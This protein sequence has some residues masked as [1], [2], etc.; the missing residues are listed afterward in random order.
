MV[1]RSATAT[2][3]TAFGKPL[4]SSV[5][6]STG[7]TA[8]STFGSM[9]LPIRSPMYSIGASSFSPSPITTTPS[10]WMALRRSRMALTAA[11]SSAFL[12]PRPIQRAAAS[13]AASVTRHSS[14]PMLRSSPPREGSV[15]P[16][17]SSGVRVMTTRSSSASRALLP[18]R[19]DRAALRGRA[20]DPRIA[21]GWSA[22]AGVEVQAQ[23]LPELFERLFGCGDG[24]TVGDFVA[25]ERGVELAGDFEASVAAVSLDGHGA[26]SEPHSVRRDQLRIAQQPEDAAL[27]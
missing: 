2:T 17:T 21:A 8:R 5:V 14:R 7:S 18:T 13:A 23:L 11:W 24:L 15:E 9:P 27:A 12:L 6:P 1:P 16:A 25:D 26:Q 19:N 10:I 4:D 3:D 20:S 22:V